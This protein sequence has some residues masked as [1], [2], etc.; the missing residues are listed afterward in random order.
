MHAGSGSSGILEWMPSQ[1]AACLH[2]QFEAQVERGPDA[3]A[4]FFEGRR[5]TYG[6]LNRR[7]NRV[8]HDLRR[9]GV[10]SEVLVGLCVERSPEM[11]VGLLGILKAGGAY[12]P[13]EPRH[14][15]ERLA[16]TIRDSGAP[17][18]VT[19]ESLVPALPGHGVDVVC[20]DAESTPAPGDRPNPS[21]GP[22]PDSIAYAIYTSG[23]TGRPK[24][25][26][27]T[28]RNVIHRLSWI[29]RAHPFEAGEVACQKTPLIFVD[30]VREI[31]APLL[32]G[33]PTVI[34]PD[35]VVIDPPRFVRA[36]ADAGVTRLSLVPS[37]L[38]GILETSDDLQARLP[39]LKRWITSGEP[40]S[41]DIAELFRRRLPGSMLLNRYGATEGSATWYD[42]TGHPAGTPVPIGRPFDD[43]EVHLLD[44]EMRPVPQGASGEIY[45]GGEGIARGYLNHPELT[46][47]RFVPRPFPGQPG[48]RL[49]R[50]GDLGRRR[51]DGEIEYLGR[52]DDQ[53]QLHGIRVELGE[54][55]ATLRQHPDVRDAAVTR[56]EGASGEATLVAHVVA[57][58]APGPSA[59]EL[60][61]FL[62]ARLPSP[63][64]PGVFAALDALPLTPT[65][66]VDRRALSIVARAGPRHETPYLAPRTRLEELIAGLWAGL[67][68]L[69]RIGVND[70]FLDLGGDS[71]LAA[72]AV[73]RT[74]DALG[75]ELPTAALLAASTVAEQSLVILEDACR[76]LGD[77]EMARLMTRA[78][79][80]GADGLA[81]TDVT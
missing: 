19:R 6:E 22:V 66:K 54:I 39:R 76:R 37:L 10:G 64:V 12:V 81:A 52:G 29:W 51:A 44:H 43:T 55:E 42:A 36:L 49:Y 65:G 62:L 27:G 34:V 56:G 31:F 46:G 1:L 35:A 63:V 80:P 74:R 72:R 71:L 50:T 79:A 32:R 41:A 59:A 17:V 15:P 47:E 67:L 68:G 20:V 2:A 28:H 13:M 45:L 77:A 73:A 4:A 14:P 24:G 26:L 16:F 60:R 7:A 78:A 5:L 38:R 40:L 61:G 69:D 57:R 11:L 70:A 48:A 8:A 30:S 9:L 23:S 3:P 33:I 53:V 25:V 58:R 21:S 75:I 18:L